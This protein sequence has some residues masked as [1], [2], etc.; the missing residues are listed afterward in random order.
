MHFPSLSFRQRKRDSNFLSLSRCL[1]MQA[2]LPGRGIE[3][4]N[5]LKLG[6]IDKPQIQK[7][8]GVKDARGREEKARVEIR[9]AACFYVKSRKKCGRL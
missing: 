5:F 4:E 6:H 9:K 8:K 2:L 7:Q 3:Q 1:Q